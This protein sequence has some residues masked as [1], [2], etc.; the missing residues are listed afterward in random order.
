[1]IFSCLNLFARQYVIINEFLTATLTS[2]GSELLLP[3]IFKPD[4]QRR[5]EPWKGRKKSTEKIFL[6]KVTF[7]LK[8]QGF[9]CGSL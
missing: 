7:T 5:K 8:Q 4:E 6:K 9:P 2:F 3:G 1:M